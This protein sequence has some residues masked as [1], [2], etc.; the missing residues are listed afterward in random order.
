[1]W[2]DGNKVKKPVQ[3][4][5]PQY[6]DYLMTWVQEQLDDEAVFPSKVCLFTTDVHSMNRFLLSG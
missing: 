4:T 2:A 3:C 1:L 5:A 6:V